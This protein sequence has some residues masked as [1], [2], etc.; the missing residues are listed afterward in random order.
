MKN[1]LFEQCLQREGVQFEYIDGISLDNIDIAKSLR[2]QARIDE[3]IVPELVE[4]Y[5]A[6]MKAGY[7]F[8]AIVLWRP[9]KGKY[10]II[11]GNQRVQAKLKCNHKHTDAY[12]V[13]STD[14]KVIDR[15]TWT[16]NNR[17]NGRR[18]TQEECML[19]ALSYVEQY[20]MTA[21]EASK[22]WGVNFTT[23]S[24]KI[25][26]EETKKELLAGNVKIHNLNDDKLRVLHPLIAIDREVLCLTAQAIIT[27]GA[28]F[29]DASMLCK[30]VRKAPSNQ[31]K[32]EVIHK[33]NTSDKAQQR[34][35]E[36]KG[37]TIPVKDNDPRNKYLRLIRQLKNH[38][39]RWDSKA[40][41][42]S[43]SDYKE[44][45][46]IILELTQEWTVEFGLGKVP[47]EPPVI[48]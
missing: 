32:L 34:K 12:I 3:A 44:I 25:R 42:P 38:K 37:G 8:P 30:E 14:K 43:K 36:T 9:G 19:H 33:F 7:E 22:E 26:A 23:L 16:I 17:V 10:I 18:L 29:E 46:E 39:G 35:A 40:L 11:D 6:H 48:E 41:M 5:S 4:S 20:G 15:I 13:L 1:S 21:T 31:A 47:L 27:T 28:S 2:N 45:R 24:N